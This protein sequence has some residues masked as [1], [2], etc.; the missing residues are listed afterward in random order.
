MDGEA[1]MSAE[2]VEEANQSDDNHSDR[3]KTRKHKLST[4]M[5][6][7][8]HKR[9]HQKKLKKLSKEMHV[10]DSKDN[11][12]KKMAIEELPISFESIKKLRKKSHSSD[13]DDNVS[14]HSYR[15]KDEQMSQ[16]DNENDVQVTISNQL[17]EKL[18]KVKKKKQKVIV[19]NLTEFQ[20]EHLRNAHVPFVE[21]KQSS[22]RKSRKNEAKFNNLANNLVDKMSI[23]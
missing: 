17:S 4:G 6:D 5:V 16:S 12:M 19:E 8:R 11:F 20:M 2:N 10:A 15:C 14:L 21:I 23:L 7:K 13:L 22:R 18:G 3:V 1:M 9:K